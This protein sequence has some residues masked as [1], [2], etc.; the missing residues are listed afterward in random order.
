[1]FRPALKGHPACVRALALRGHAVDEA[2]ATDGLQR[3]PLHWAMAC[4][5]DSG[6]VATVFALAELG[7]PVDAADTDGTTPMHLAAM[8]GNV[9]LLAALHAVGARVDGGDATS[10][11]KTPLAE[12][13]ERGFDAAV[14]LLR[15]LGA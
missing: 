9:T 7:A 5:D 15:K 13:H 14:K 1:M 3:V 4:L 10:W 2:M 8:E 12:A 6:A 11:R